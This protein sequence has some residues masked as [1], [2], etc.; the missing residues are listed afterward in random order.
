MPRIISLAILIL[1]V[2]IYIFPFPQAPVQTFFLEQEVNEMK[3]DLVGNWAGSQEIEKLDGN[4]EW[5][6]M[7]SLKMVE[8]LITSDSLYFIGEK[9]YEFDFF[10]KEHG[11]LIQEYSND[12]DI[13]IKKLSRDSLVF[14]IRSF[15]L[16]EKHLFTLKRGPD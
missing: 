11:S 8:L 9:A 14:E 4:F 10:S 7:D 15:E 6:K 16:D 2:K 1:A 5:Q 3:V 13:E 12:D